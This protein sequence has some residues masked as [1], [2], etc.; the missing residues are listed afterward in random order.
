MYIYMLCIYIYIWFINM[1]SITF[2]GSSSSCPLS[3]RGPAAAEAARRG[4]RCATQLRGGDGATAPEIYSM[5][6][7]TIY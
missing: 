7:G 6:T 1:V 2:T 3:G 5:A 4:A